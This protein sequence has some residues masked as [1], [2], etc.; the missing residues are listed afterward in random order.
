MKLVFH[1][2][3]KTGGASLRRGA[4]AENYPGEQLL[5]LYEPPAGQGAPA[6]SVEAYS[7]LFESIPPGEWAAIRC[8]AGHGTQWALAAL[9]EPARAF[10][11]IRDPVERVISLHYYL[12]ARSDEAVDQ[13]AVAGRLIRERDWSI[14]DV[15]EHVAEAER[16]SEP[17]LSPFF[18]YFDGQTRAIVAP[19][20]GFRLRAAEPTPA[21]E[22][23]I[24]ETLEHVLRRYVLGCTS[25]WLVSMHVFARELGWTSTP[26]LRVNKTRDRPATNDLP[27]ETIELIRRHNRL[28][29]EL[30]AR[31]FR[32]V[33]ERAEQLGLVPAHG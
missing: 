16:R 29:E 15:Y 7:E 33:R 26:T 19:H 12:R 24:R 13:G 4:L 25:S 3:T 6:P 23:A 17:A 8:I 5:A 31:A 14:A 22:S 10:S 1:H 9:R 21:E 30:H 11:L 2:L 28:D 27:E 20:L 18:Q 32:E